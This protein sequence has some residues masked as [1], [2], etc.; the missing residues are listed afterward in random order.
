MVFRFVL[1]I[2]E[3][4]LRKRHVEQRRNC[5]DAAKSVIFFVSFLLFTIVAVPS[6]ME[7]VHDF[8]QHPFLWYLISTISYLFTLCPTVDSDPFFNNFNMLTMYPIF[9]LLYCRVLTFVFSE[10]LKRLSLCIYWILLIAV[11]VSRF[12]NISRSSKVERILLRKYYHLMA[13]LMFLPAL[14]LQVTS[15][16]CFLPFYSLEVLK[17]APVVASYYL[18]VLFIQPKFLD[19]AFGAALAVFVALEIIRVSPPSLPNYSPS[20]FRHFQWD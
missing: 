6:W 9:I 10:P 5:S 2:Y 17:S 18:H 15:D 19:L 16:Q 7:F 13:V 20:Q 11:S 8:H 14:V 3:S 1:S 4:F 12:Y